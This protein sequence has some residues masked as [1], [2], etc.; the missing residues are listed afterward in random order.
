MPGIVSAVV[1]GSDRNA[2]PARWMA[3]VTGTFDDGTVSRVF[4]FYD[5]ELSFEGREFVGLTRE[6]ALNLFR[7]KDIAYLQS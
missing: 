1:T 2:R 5:D 7:K 3:E 6:E 4:E